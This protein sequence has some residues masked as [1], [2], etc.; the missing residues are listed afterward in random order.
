MKLKVEVDSDDCAEPT[1][2]D[3][4]KA[5]D[6]AHHRLIMYGALFPEVQNYSEDEKQAYIGRVFEQ[7]LPE[8]ME[9]KKAGLLRTILTT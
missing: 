5:M 1:L 6:I 3:K 7:V 8:I 2:E 9:K 4:F